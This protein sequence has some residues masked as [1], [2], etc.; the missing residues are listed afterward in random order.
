M[1]EFLASPST[2]RAYGSAQPHDRR[3]S[4]SKIIVLQGQEHVNRVAR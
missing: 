2:R 4:Q 1:V 3:P